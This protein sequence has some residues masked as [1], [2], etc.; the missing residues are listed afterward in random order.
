MRALT[1]IV[2]IALAIVSAA[3]AVAQIEPYP[4]KPVRIMMPF[5]PADRATCLRG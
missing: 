5:P 2:V 1:A 4:N 3:P